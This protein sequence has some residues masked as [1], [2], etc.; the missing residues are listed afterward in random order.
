[1]SSSS[2]GFSGLLGAV[3]ALGDGLL[4]SLEKRLQLIALELHEEKLNFVRLL[5]WLGAI[6]VTGLLGLAFASLA[7]LQFCGPD[8]RLTVLLVLAGVYLG[9]S[10]ALVL[11]F[12][13]FLLRQPAPFAA[14]LDELGKDRACIRK[15][16]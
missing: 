1:M 12:R 14:S 5:L 8:S 3:R 7:L 16:S 2:T 9:G 11:A 10:F 6:L 15:A 4:G 13:R